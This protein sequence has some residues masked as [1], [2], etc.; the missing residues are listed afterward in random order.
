MLETLLVLVLLCAVG[1]SYKYAWWR[2]AV[3][4]KQPRILMYH[5]IAEPKKGQKFRG[6]RVA[7]HM[8]E[9]QLAWFKQHGWHFMTMAELQAAD[10]AQPEKTVVITF[11]DGFE[12]NY[13]QALPLLK[14]Y[15]AKATLYLVEDRH[16]RDWSTA[17]KAHHDSGELAA[18]PKL[19]DEQV[20][21]MLASGVFELGG[22]TR[23]H[24]NLAV[25]DT[26][27]KESEIGDS[28][29]ALEALFNT[30]IN[31][32]AYPFGIYKDSDPG[33]VEQ[34]GYSNAVTT[35]DGM[36][37]DLKQDPFELKRIKI[38]GKDNFL[39]FKIRIKTG[40]RGLKK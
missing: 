21:Q 26:G 27:S 30:K 33:L 25:E 7:P 35:I 24:C 8:F 16:N 38:S 1:F 39:A 23:T 2:R 22:H 20:Q 19:S 36:Q 13:T 28:K 6:L 10:G 12:D 3:D 17:K 29:Q 4:Y 40:K 37:A 31:S 15:G 9:R 11:D 34:L 18:I 14:K 5:M 32:F